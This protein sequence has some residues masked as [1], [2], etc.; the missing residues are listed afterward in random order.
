MVLRISGVLSAGVLGLGLVACGGGGGSSIAPPPV[1][2]PP[3][4]PP[5]P[6]PV[7]R[8]FS[9][10]QAAVDASVATNMAILVG[11]ETGVLFA[12]EKGTFTTDQEVSIASASKMAFGL[13]I[14]DLVESGDLSLAD[15]PQDHIG[16]WTDMAGDGRSEITLDQLLGFTS[17]FN[18]PPGNAGCIGQGSVSLSDCVEQVYDEGLDTLAG[19]AFYYGPEHMQIAA[20][21]ATEAT[22]KTNAA[23]LDERL[24]QPYGLSS[25]TRYPALR[26][27]NPRYSGNMV[28]TAD[29]YALWLAA[30]LDGRLVSDRTGYLEDR[31]ATVTF[32]SRPDGLDALDW[33]Y[34]FGFWKECDDLSYTSACDANPTISSPGAFGFTPW[35]DFDAGYWGIIA[36]EETVIGGQAASMVSV[37]LEQ[38]VQPLIEAAL[39]P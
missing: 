3:P 31:T 26:G 36:M 21:M 15:N 8:D 9:A 22:G 11:D 19:S 29:D 10:V 30:I 20:L 16:F 25:M 2:M 4:P 38:Q 27:D 1:A 33:H 7:S 13:L 14:W 32:G 6:P 34:G 35:I 17:G 24:I 37:E 23:L 39:T 18:N 28:S 5:P 12:Y